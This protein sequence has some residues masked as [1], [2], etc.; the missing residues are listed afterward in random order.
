[1]K[2]QDV[3]GLIVYLLIFALAIVFGLTVLREHSAN[4]GLKTALYVVYVLGA[5]ITGLILNS[6]IYEL[7]HIVGAKLGRY[8]II[9]VCI[10]GCTFFKQ[11]KKWKFKFGGFDG[12][13]GE[14]KI[15]PKTEGKPSNPTPF[16]LFGTLFYMVEALLFAIAFVILKGIKDNMAAANTAYFL[17]IVVVIG[18]MIL[19]YNI[20]PFQ[21]D[22][23]TDG[24]RLKMISNPKNKEAFNE[25]LR[26]ENA[27]ENGDKNVEIKTFTEITNFTADLNYNK[28]YVCLENGDYKTAEEMIDLVI[29]AKATVSPKVFL[30]AKAQKI[31]IHIMS[32]SIEK[33]AE[34]YD[35]EVPVSDRREISSDISME[36]IRA[37]ILM[38][39]IL[40][41]SKSETTLALN[42]VLK[43]FKK[44]SIARQPIELKLYNQAL[45]KVIDDIPGLKKQ[46]QGNVGITVGADTNNGTNSNNGMFDF[47]F[48]GVRPRKQ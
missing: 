18:A 19:I 31:Y 5:I 36:S 39:G 9:S 6:A 27:I 20:M 47:G 23:L 43:A 10:L 42:N 16:L 46:V 25:L 3:T 12:L 48:A 21:L 34:F 30:R 37:Y 29:N 40:D 17:L 8:S 35:K 44:T 38:S 32:D 24:Y 4:S 33:A 7:G 45:Q 28:V 41:K 13:T 2:K 15:A 11:D 14:T 26:V 22:S 1:M